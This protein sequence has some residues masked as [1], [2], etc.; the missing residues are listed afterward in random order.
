[1]YPKGR[2][3]HFQRNLAD[4]IEFDP[5]FHYYCLQMHRQG[6]LLILIA[7]SIAFLGCRPSNTL[8]MEAQNPVQAALKLTTPTIHEPAAFQASLRISN[9]SQE[10]IR[11]N[12]LTATVSSL[13]LDVRDSGGEL[14][15]HLPPPVPNEEAMDA[16]WQ[17]I[18]SGQ[19]HEFSLTDLSVDVSL[20]TPGS[21][22]V[23]FVGSY[24][25]MDAI[26]IS[27]ISLSSDWATLTVIP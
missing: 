18:P 10:T 17:Q 15:P 19:S 11:V 6:I 16:A 1:M 23:R 25:K 8:S 21:Y 7:L 12:A 2:K 9:N 24:Y 20:L 14:L 26:Q 27:E 22:Q 5:H 4:F 13:S 3:R